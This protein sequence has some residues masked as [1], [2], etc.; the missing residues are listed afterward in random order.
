MRGWDEDGKDWKR[1]IDWEEKKRGKDR[2]MGDRT[3][4]KR[5]KD[6]KGRKRRRGLGEEEERK[7][8]GKGEKKGRKIEEQ[9]RRV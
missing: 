2:R 7:I 8:D 3:D 1:I 4:G 5:G 9:K 6:W